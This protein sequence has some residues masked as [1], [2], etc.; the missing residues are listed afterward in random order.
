MHWL[1]IALSPLL[2]FLPLD[3]PV[4]EENDAPSTL[5]SQEVWTELPVD[6]SEEEPETR[7]ESAP[8]PQAAPLPR[9]P[10]VLI[11]R[12][13]T[14]A[15]WSAARTRIQ[16]NFDDLRRGMRLPFDSWDFDESMDTWRDGLDIYAEYA[17]AL[18]GDDIEQIERDVRILEVLSG[19]LVIDYEKGNPVHIEATVRQM[20]QVLQ[21]LEHRSTQA[22]ARAGRVDQWGYAMFPP[23]WGEPRYRDGD[24]ADGLM[25]HSSRELAL[26]IRERYNRLFRI[27]P[28]R[29]ASDTETISREVVEL[30]RAL[31]RR[32]SELPDLSRPGFRNATMRL[33]VIAENIVEFSREHDRHGYNRQVVLLGETLRDLESFLVL[34]EANQP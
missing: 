34:S 32:Q 24:F 31:A 14:A 13:P 20:D 29:L 3:P 1:L 19:Y 33:E 27:H 5:D 7:V 12:E 17:V 15:A 21:R 28:D 22:D 11:G 6:E 9:D 18:A 4:E 16:K 23:D 26:M 2:P 8:L 25:F 30:S 10:E